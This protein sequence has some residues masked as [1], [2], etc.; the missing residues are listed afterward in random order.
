MFVQLIFGIQLE[1]THS[2]KKIILIYLW[3]GIGGVLFSAL[4]TDL[5]SVGASCAIMGLL[6][7]ILGHIILNWKALDYP[8]SS[9]NQ[10]VCFISFI[11]IFNLL[12]AVMS[13]VTTHP[14]G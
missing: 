14:A 9:R 13:A 10:I 3:T 1:K 8:G 4:M 7:S 12:P 6:G 11:I 5:W 2:T